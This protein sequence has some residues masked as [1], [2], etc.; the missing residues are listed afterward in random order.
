MDTKNGTKMFEA[1]ML[2]WALLAFSLAVIATYFP[3]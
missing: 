1:Q 2:R 3:S